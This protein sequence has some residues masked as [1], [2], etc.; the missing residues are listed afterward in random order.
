MNIF[1]YVKILWFLKIS[2][3]FGFICFI[4]KIVDIFYIIIIFIFYK[5]FLNENK[6]FCE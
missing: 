6:I 5:I 2:F 3:I 4:L 1:L